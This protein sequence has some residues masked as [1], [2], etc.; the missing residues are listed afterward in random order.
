MS[1]L[2]S[3]LGLVLVVEGLVWAA[4]PGTAMRMLEAA[5]HLPDQTLRT[6]GLSVLATGVVLV[7]LVKG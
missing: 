7:W 1:E 5:S 6:I 2:I 3:A 4:F